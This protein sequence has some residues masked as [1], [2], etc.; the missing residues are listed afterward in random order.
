LAKF[1]QHLLGP[2]T[3]DC[4]VVHRTVSGA[5]GWPTVNWLFSEN[6]R[7]VRLKFTGLSGGAVSQRRSRP[8]VGCAI[9]GRR[10]ARSNGRLGTPD[11]VWCANQPRGATVG[12]ARYGRRS[13]TGH[14]QWLSGGAPDCPV[15]HSTEGRNC[16]PSWCPT[17]PSCLGAI[18]ETPRRMDGFTKLTR[19][20]LRHLDSAF[21]QSDHSS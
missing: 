13:R 1:S 17:T 7:G 3:P 16:L 4:P 11:N 6:D 20:I 8:T 5:L 12:C 15:H 9:R 18:K 21:T 10:V 19:N 14:E 2:G